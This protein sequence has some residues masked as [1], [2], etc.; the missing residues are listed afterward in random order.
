M[1][2]T[3]KREE[4]MEIA[5]TEKKLEKWKGGKRN[6]QQEEKWPEHSSQRQRTE[7]KE[8]VSFSCL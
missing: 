6:E 4:K 8:N 3:I 2:N 7:S 1:R 5:G